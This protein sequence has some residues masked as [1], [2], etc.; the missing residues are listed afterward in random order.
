M[1]RQEW[2]N[3]RH[4]VAAK[5]HRCE[6]CAGSPGILKGEEHLKFVGEYEGDFQSWR[7][8]DDCEEAREAGRIDDEPICNQ[9]HIR[10]KT[11]ED[12]GHT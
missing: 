12:S 3:F 9:G 10:G 2:N 4:V 6:W 8:H 11:C 5:D 1:P 7:I